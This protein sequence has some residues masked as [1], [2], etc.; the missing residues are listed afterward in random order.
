VKNWKSGKLDSKFGGFIVFI[1]GVNFRIVAT[2][3]LGKF[4]NFICFFSV[5]SEKK[6]ASKLGEKWHRD[7]T[8]LPTLLNHFA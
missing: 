8:Y 2:K 1:L 3:R 4:W 5:N 7:F 6:I